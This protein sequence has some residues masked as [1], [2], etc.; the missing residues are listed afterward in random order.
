MKWLL[1]AAFAIGC[2]NTVE[3]L[4]TPAIDGA[5]ADAAIDPKDGSE[6]GDDAEVIDA[7][8]AIEDAGTAIEDAAMPDDGGIAPDD[9]GL[10]SGVEAYGP[11]DQNGAETFTA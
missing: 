7:G 4:D 1:A 8:L 6:L 2:S 5:I 10:D 3:P 9:A 11:Y